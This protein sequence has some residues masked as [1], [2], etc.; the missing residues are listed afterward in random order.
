LSSVDD[1]VHP[2]GVTGQFVRDI[3][4]VAGCAVLALAVRAATLRRRTA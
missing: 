3:G 4:V 2:S 1:V